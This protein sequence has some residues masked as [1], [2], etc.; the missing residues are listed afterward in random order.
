VVANGELLELTTIALE[1]HT[2]TYRLKDL[3]ARLDPA[4]FVRLSR[5]AIVNVDLIARISPMPGGTFTVTLKNNLQLP[6]S[7]LRAR[8]LREELLRL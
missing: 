5:G 8:V 4:K 3:E 2:I 1:R 6:V 7:R